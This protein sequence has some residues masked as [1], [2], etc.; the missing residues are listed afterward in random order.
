MG[1]WGETRTETEGGTLVRYTAIERKTGRWSGHGSVE[2]VKWR[3]V[4][5]DPSVPITEHRTKRDALAALNPE[6]TDSTNGAAS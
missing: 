3:A 2:R 1:F 6:P 5:Y 4:S